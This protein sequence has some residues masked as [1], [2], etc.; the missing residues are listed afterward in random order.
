MLYGHLEGFRVDN[1]PIRGPI[2]S[3]LY[4]NPKLWPTA[5]RLKSREPHDVIVRSFLHL[6]IMYSSILNHRP[7]SCLNPMILK[8]T[9]NHALFAERLVKFSL[10]AR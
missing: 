8:A 3:A 1:I 9:T 5:Q 6:S 10:D 2:A 7:A 4:C